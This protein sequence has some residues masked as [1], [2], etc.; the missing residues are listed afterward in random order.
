VFPLL[1]DPGKARGGAPVVR[2]RTAKDVLDD[3]RKQPGPARVIQVNHPRSGSNGYFDLLGFDPKTGMGTAP[4][5]DSVFDAIEVWNGRNVEARTKTLEDF[6]ALLRTGHPVTATADT[7]THG[8]VGQEPGLPRTFVRVTKDDAL[9]TWDAA[10]TDDLVKSVRERRDVVL[11]NGPFMKVTANG[12]GIG[13]VAR[14]G[15]VDVKVHVTSAP[16]AAVDHAEIRLAGRG[17]VIG[18]SRVALSPKKNAAG[19]LEA[20]ASFTVRASADDAFVV[21]VS[22]GAPM[23]PMFT[24]EDKELT[25]YAM[26]GAI[27]IDA[28]GDG[29]SLGR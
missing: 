25:P 7:D 21:M 8:I 5:Y 9:E 26:S 14:G 18:P 11:T 10:R 27:W 24:G 1:A 16:F 2:D 3:I 28:D 29:T 17:K 6:L 15:Q 23:R 22:G 19:A 20:D 4:G 12:V 13:G